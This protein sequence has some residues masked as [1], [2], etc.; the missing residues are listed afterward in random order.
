[1][2]SLIR[3]NPFQLI[4]TEIFSAHSGDQSAGVDNFHAVF[5]NVDLPAFLF[6]RGVNGVRQNRLISDDHFHSIFNYGEF[7]TFKSLYF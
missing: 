5:E 1:M 2:P 4:C 3:S 6:T 7:A